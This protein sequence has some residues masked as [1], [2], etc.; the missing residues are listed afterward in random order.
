MSRVPSEA[1]KALFRHAVEHSRPRVARP[2]KAKKPA[3]VKPGGSG[4]DGNTQEKLRRGALRPEAR[5]DL[6]GYTEEAAHHALLSF[7]ERAQKGGLRL[8]L[9]VTGKGN[10]KNEDGAGWTMRRHG[11]LKEMVPRWLNERAFAAL[12]AGTA[13]AHLR[14]G[15]GGALYVYLRKLR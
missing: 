11:I 15:G 14:H 5:I 4:L 7:L 8:V 2:A 3:A 9:V 6:H 12:I 13:A 10:P 1:E